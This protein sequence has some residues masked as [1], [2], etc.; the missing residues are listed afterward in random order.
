MAYASFKY[1]SDRERKRVEKK[2]QKREQERLREYLLTLEKKSR[3][4]HDKV[5]RAPNRASGNTKSIHPDVREQYLKQKR[6]EYFDRELDEN[7][8]PSLDDLTASAPP[9][10]IKDYFKLKPREP[11][12]NTN[13][14]K[15]GQE[16]MSK[17]LKKVF[18]HRYWDVTV[19]KIDPEK[20][21]K[22]RRRNKGGRKNKTRRRKKKGGGKKE[23]IEINKN[24]ND[25]RKIQRDI[26]KI[27]Q[28]LDNILISPEE[29]DTYDKLPASAFKTIDKIR[30]SSPT[31]VG[32]VPMGGKRKTKKRKS[33]KKRRRTRKRKKNRKKRT[34]RR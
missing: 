1:L 4:K 5:Y 29:D 3:V 22:T 11:V 18:G 30:S 24:K 21:L 20:V 10:I 27:K 13:K 15:Q 17:P 14:T 12:T 6:D 9:K 7:P 23:I 16:E 25:I 8:L 31:S 2:R 32:E 34:K 26:F 19:E 33:C 28:E